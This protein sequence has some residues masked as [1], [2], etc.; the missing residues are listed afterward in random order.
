MGTK[1]LQEEVD[2]R[3][4]RVFLPF[5][6]VL[7][8]LAFDVFEPTIAHLRGLKFLDNLY[9]D[10]LLLFEAGGVAGSSS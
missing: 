2:F 3:A 1:L 6:G 8:G 10:T 9:M 4:F 5:L 7:K